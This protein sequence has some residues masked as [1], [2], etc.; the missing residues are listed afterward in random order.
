MHYFDHETK[1]AP[2]MWKYG[3]PKKAD[4]LKSLVKQ[5]YSQIFADRYEI[6]LTHAVSFGYMFYA[7]CHI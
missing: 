3:E 5:M 6:I 1:G 4:V 2:S 7:I